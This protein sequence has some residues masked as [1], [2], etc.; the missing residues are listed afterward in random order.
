MTP[1]TLADAEAQMRAALD[2]GDRDRI[3]AAVNLVDQF[4]TAAAQ[5]DMLSAALW[6]AETGLHVFALRPLSKMPFGKC[7]ACKDDDCTGPDACGHDQCHGV[8]DATTDATRITAWWTKSPTANIGLA[9]GHLV[10]VVD[11]DGLEGQR[12]RTQHWDPTF[13]RIENDGVA[14]V[15]TPRPGGMHIYVPATGDGNGAHLFPGI[16]YRGVGGYVVAPPSSNEQGTYRFL[17]TP[18]FAAVSRAA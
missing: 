2:S 9:C 11:I 3:D 17:G 14:K 15:L 16:D 7:Q 4:E 6:Y 1:Y 13:E 8:K 5:P 10:D 18:D 12:S